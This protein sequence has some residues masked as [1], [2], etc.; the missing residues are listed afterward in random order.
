M[1][2]GII[3]AL[4]DKSFLKKM[5]FHRHIKRDSELLCFTYSC[6]KSEAGTQPS[7]PSANTIRNQLPS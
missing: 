2:S 3:L 4:E 6:F 1:F 5:R 7:L